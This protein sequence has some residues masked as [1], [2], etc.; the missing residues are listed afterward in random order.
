MIFFLYGTQE[1]ILK[2]MLFNL[3][4]VILGFALDI[5]SEK[6]SKERKPHSE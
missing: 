4:H 6:Q 1:E 5:L 3:F 2:N